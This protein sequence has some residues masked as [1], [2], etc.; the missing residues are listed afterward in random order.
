VVSATLLKKKKNV[1]EEGWPIHPQGVA[2]HPLG[3]GCGSATTKP[4][5][6]GH[7]VKDKKK[8]T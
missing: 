6:F 5:G 4:G 8:K 7:P 1:K 3:H 2:D